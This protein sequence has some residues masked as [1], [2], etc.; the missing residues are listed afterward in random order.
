MESIIIKQNEQIIQLKKELESEKQSHKKTILQKESIE[1]K[2]IEK[3][4]KIKR[5]HNWKSMQLGK[6]ILDC[7]TLSGI[8]RLPSLLLKIFKKKQLIKLH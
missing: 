1:K 6:A 7:R 8:I 5:M 4:N 2:L 3:E